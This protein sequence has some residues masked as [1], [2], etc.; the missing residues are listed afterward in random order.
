MF[1]GC[2]TFWPQVASGTDNG[3]DCALLHC[4]HWLT[5]RKQLLPSLSSAD[6]SVTLTHSLTSKYSIDIQKTCESVDGEGPL[7]G[8][9][10]C[11]GLPQQ[12]CSELLAGR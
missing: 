5:C 2:E 9:L 8:S 12:L 3:H 1:A 7:K 10:H 11:T 6:L 4:Q